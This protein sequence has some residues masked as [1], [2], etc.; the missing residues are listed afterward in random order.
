VLR[1]LFVSQDEVKT[2]TR[3]YE[4]IR[5]LKNDQ[6]HLKELYLASHSVGRKWHATG[7]MCG[8]AGGV[9]TA[10]LG[11]L[12]SAGAWA[13]GDETSGLSLHGVGA[14]FLLSTI[15]LLFGGAHCLDLLEKRVKKSGRVNS[16]GAPWRQVSRDERGR[17]APAQSADLR[18]RRSGRA[19]H[20][21]QAH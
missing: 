5:E 6:A 20:R 7:A 1:A 15:P 10:I 18:L 2:V 19:V 8:L 21:H 3:D 13:L 11:T 9:A 17:L 14:I 16:A 4:P 12:L